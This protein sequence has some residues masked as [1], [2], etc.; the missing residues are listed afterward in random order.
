MNP[1][2]SILIKGKP[3]TLGSKLG[4]GVQGN[5]FNMVEVDNVV[6]KIINTNS[7]SKDEINITRKRL[8][9]LLNEIGKTDLKHRLALPKGLL[10]NQLGYVMLKASE[11]ENLYKYIQINNEDSKNWLKENYSLKKRYQ[12]IL[13]LFQALRDIH[14]QGLIFTD[15]SPNNIMYHKTKNQ[16]VFIDTDNLR[17][18]TEKYLS[19]LGTPGYMAPEIYHKVD[20]SLAQKGKICESVFSKSGIISPDSDIYSA[21]IIAFQLLTLQHPF[22]GDFVEDGTADLEEKALKGE[23]DYIFK[24]DT[25]NF[26]TSNL[27]PYF[28]TLTTH[29][30]RKLFEKTF[31]EGKENPRLR[32]TDIDF[33]EEFQKAADMVISCPECGFDNLYFQNQDFYCSLCGQTIHKNMVL[34]IYIE[35]EENNRKNL[36]NNIVGR[37]LL[38]N[39]SLIEGINLIEVSRIV[40]EPNVPKILYNSHFDN[41]IIKNEPYAKIEWLETNTLSFTVL[42]EKYEYA[43]LKEYKTTTSVPLKSGKVFI[44]SDFYIYFERIES[45]ITPY[46]IIGKIE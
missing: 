29:G 8:E 39:D 46:K 31:I 9:W 35:F 17:K 45:S 14:L 34:K 33:I 36:I 11:H 40:L 24:K 44:T 7:M 4:Q 30:I 2:D 38:D 12:I 21:A 22:I 20:I 27:S 3:Y 10:D 25:N 26:S 15:L 19:V 37:E 28:D 1:G 43:S 6:V 18:R 16:I 23:T 13:I 42:T 32:P 41:T 5:V